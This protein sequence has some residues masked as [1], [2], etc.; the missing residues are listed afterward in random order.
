[1][2]ISNNK[3]STVIESNVPFFV[4]NDHQQF[5]AFLKAYYEFMEQQDGVINQA[6]NILAY[7]DV[8]YTIDQFEE[9]LHKQ[10]LKLIPKDVEFD[11]NLL[12]KNVKDLYRARGTEKAIRF[13]L[14]ALYKVTSEFYYPKVDILRASAGNWFVEKSLKINDVKRNGV[15]DNSPETV[16]LFANTRVVGTTSNA[17]AIIERTETYYEVGVPIN[18]FKV[19]SQVNEFENGETLTTTITENGEEVQLSCN[20]FSGTIASVFINNPGSFYRLGDRATILAVNSVGSGAIVEVS[21]V[22]DGRVISI[23]IAYSG[24]GFVANDQILFTGGGG[25]GATGYVANVLS[26]NS[27]HS[28]IYTMYGATID[29]EANTPISNATYSNLAP[30]A[31]ANIAMGNTWTTWI[32]GNTGPMATLVLQTTGNNYLF[33]PLTDVQSNTYIRGLGIL[34][35]MKINNGGIG[36]QINDKINFFG[37]SGTGAQGNVKNVAANG[38]IT[39]VGFD[40]VEGHHLGGSGYS[41]LMLPVANVI[42]STGSGANVVVTSILGDGESILVSSDTIGAI[43]EMRIVSGGAGY[44]EEPNVDMTLIGDGEARI[45]A[46][47]ITGVYTYPG[48]Y[49]ND[50]GHLSGYNFLE[51]RDY[52]QPFSYVIRTNKSLNDYRDVLLSLLHPTG[53]K[54][55]GE[56]LFDEYSYQNDASQEFVSV[57]KE[58]F[59]IVPATYYFDDMPAIRLNNHGLAKG[60][61]VTLEFTSGNLLNRMANN[62]YTVSNVI[63]SNV[64]QVYAGREFAQLQMYKFVGSTDYVPQDA[65]ISPDGTKAYFCG[66]QNK[67]FQLKLNTPYD[68]TTAQNA[69]VSNTQINAGNIQGMSFDP[70]G[71]YLYVSAGNGPSQNVVQLYLPDAWNVNTVI[72]MHTLNVSNESNAVRFME[73]SGDGSRIY[74]GNL[75]NTIVHSYTLNTAWNIATAS[76]PAETT[77]FVNSGMQGF[78]F[79]PDGNSFFYFNNSVGSSRIQQRNVSS[80]WNISTGT[81]VANS[82]NITYPVGSSIGYR[83]FSI[84][85]DGRMIYIASSGIGGLANQNTIIQ[86]PLTQAWNIQTTTFDVTSFGNVSIGVSL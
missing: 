32:Y 13:I 10:F 33:A 60:N 44:L 21:K 80:P 45:T 48:R 17:Q 73:I 2:T 75:N 52:Y 78:R 65:V 7:R 72:Q 62:I 12:L 41:Q 64:V 24:A 39:E 68:I 6:K 86:V 84:S 59:K 29:L 74:I 76:F 56:Y 36:Y 46:N 1:M 61:V 23:G 55:F 19:S 22:T 54:M 42:T 16:R 8:D 14:S 5:V 28:N 15:L 31:N 77:T 57:E 4:R 53:M 40:P 70:T 25:I 9:E 63:N 38:M 18:E 83:G 20:V 50:D 3:I 35:R 43:Q 58:A 27:I 11:K 71:K 85:T 30:P 81:V 66:P 51:D 37:G 82:G 69:F 67:V 49:L 26:D 47:I 79:N 34:A